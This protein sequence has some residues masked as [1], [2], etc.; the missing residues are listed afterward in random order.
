MTLTI[1]MFHNNYP[2]ILNYKTIDSS[3]PMCYVECHNV[4]IFSLEK[5]VTLANSVILIISECD[6]LRPPDI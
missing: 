1:D 3:N 2:C 5:L 6:T 4:N